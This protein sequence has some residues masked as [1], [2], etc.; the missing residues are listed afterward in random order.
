ME[1]ANLDVIDEMK[2]ETMAM[3][4]LHGLVKVVFHIIAVLGCLGGLLVILEGF[5]RF[6]AKM[7]TNNVATEKVLIASFSGVLV[8][9]LSLTVLGLAYGY[10]AMVKAQIDS[11]NAIV[12]FTQ[13]KTEHCYETTN[14]DHEIINQDDL[15]ESK[16]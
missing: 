8:I 1:E 11:R 14:Q 15:L 16:V 5:N 3:P 12:S 10:F 4:K 13:M 9:V 2:E 7:M 6:G